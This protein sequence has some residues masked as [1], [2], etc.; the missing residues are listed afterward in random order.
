[1]PSPSPVRPWHGEQ[2]T[3]NRSCPRA[4][5]FASIGNG[6]AVASLPFSLPPYSSG[7]SFRWPRATVPA[8]IG[9]A[10]SESEKKADCRS[11]VY[12]GWSCMSC[13][14]AVESAAASARIA[15]PRTEE[16][17]QFWGE[18]SIRNGCHLPG[19]ERFE[20]GARALEMEPR[21]ARLD[22][23]EEPVAAGERE[24]RHVE[25][26]VIRL[27]Q[28][29]QRQHAEHRGK[30]GAE[31]RALEGDRD[32]RRP[33]VKPP[34]ADVER[35]RLRRRPVLQQVPGQAADDPANQH[36]QRQPRVVEPDRLV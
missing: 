24:P 17:V 3:S 35:V 9:R 36:D 14:Q 18:V 13:R 5:T 26:R 7:S 23:Q 28:A 15:S 10:D 1:M 29:V 34:A 8:T 4:M 32:E 16:Q 22:A 25:H 2:Y 12:L 31:D 11:G 21:I 33:A 20:E 6:K 19:T 30:R 27:R